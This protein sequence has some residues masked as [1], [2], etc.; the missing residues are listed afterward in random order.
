MNNILFQ[1]SKICQKKRG[2]LSRDQLVNVLQTNS[3]PLGIEFEA[4]INVEGTERTLAPDEKDDSKQ[5]CDQWCG[6]CPESPD[7]INDS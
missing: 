7:H 3:A 1:H 4:L 6:W 2:A 5:L